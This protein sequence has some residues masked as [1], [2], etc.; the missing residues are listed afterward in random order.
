MTTVKQKAH[1]IIEDLQADIETI[2]A[3]KKE[4]ME[5]IEGLTNLERLLKHE[6]KHIEEVAL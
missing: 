6:I 4:A 3:R 2:Q 1:I 5:Y